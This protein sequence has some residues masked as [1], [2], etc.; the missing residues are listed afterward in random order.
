[1][2][3]SAALN[4]GDC[5][6]SGWLCRVLASVHLTLLPGCTPLYSLPI[7]KPVFYWGLRDF[8]TRFGNAWT[9]RLPLPPSKA[10]LYR[11]VH[12]LG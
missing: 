11:F 1:M 5:D 10:N 3:V 12:D 4:E 6:S 2:A 7:K 9:H 8:Q